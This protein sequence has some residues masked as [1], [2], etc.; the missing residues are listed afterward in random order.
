MGDDGET[1]YQ[2]VCHDFGCSHGCYVENNYPYC[3]CPDGQV[4]D[5]KICATFLGGTFYNSMIINL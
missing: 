2:D 3:C 1:C 4:L 5:G